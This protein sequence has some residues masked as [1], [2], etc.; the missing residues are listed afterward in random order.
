MW[1]QVAQVFTNVYRDL[2]DITL[3]SALKTTS[4]SEASPLRAPPATSR[5][6]ALFLAVLSSPP[7]QQFPAPSVSGQHPSASGMSSLPSPGSS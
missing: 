3:K 4:K 2:S 5:L 7:G 1:L 6:S